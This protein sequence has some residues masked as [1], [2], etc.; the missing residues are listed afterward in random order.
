MIRNGPAA[1]F[2]SS[3]QARLPALA[4]SGHLKEQRGLNWLLGNV[5]QALAGSGPLP[6]PARSTSI[7]VLRLPFFTKH[8]TMIAERRA[9]RKFV[10]QQ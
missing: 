10:A 6:Y 7:S 8:S 5:G 9:T 1:T 2:M 3:S 4:G